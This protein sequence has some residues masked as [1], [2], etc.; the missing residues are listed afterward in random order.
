MDFLK[1]QSTVASF[2]SAIDMNVRQYCCYLLMKVSPLVWDLQDTQDSVIKHTNNVSSSETRSRTHKEMMVPN[3]IKRAR[4]LI[5]N[6]R[7]TVEQHK[8]TP[9]S[10]IIGPP[11]ITVPDFLIRGYSLPKKLLKGETHR[12]MMIT[13]PISINGPYNG[14]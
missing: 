4:R 7:H 5:L 8:N 6:P 14:S 13:P 3:T 11:N 9:S 12:P 10:A 2:L 1:P